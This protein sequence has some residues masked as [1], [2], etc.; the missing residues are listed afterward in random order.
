MMGLKSLKQ[1]LSGLEFIYAVETTREIHEGKCH[2]GMSA[3]VQIIAR[4]SERASI[5]SVIHIS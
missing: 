5:T 3:V 4:R 2:H 1:E